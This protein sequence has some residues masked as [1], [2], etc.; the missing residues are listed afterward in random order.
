M[1]H[2]RRFVTV[3]TVVFCG[4]ATFLLAAPQAL[5]MNLAPAGGGPIGQASFANHQAMTGWEIAF[6]TLAAVVFLAIV[7]ILARLRSLV[8]RRSVAA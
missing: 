6:I 7:A 5:A 1:K 4:V 3:A 2:L 8:V